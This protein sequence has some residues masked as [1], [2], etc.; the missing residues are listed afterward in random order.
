MMSNSTYSDIGQMLMDVFLV[1][2]RGMTLI[3][4]YYLRNIISIF[5]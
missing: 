4:L 1:Q 2:D 5:M 3:G